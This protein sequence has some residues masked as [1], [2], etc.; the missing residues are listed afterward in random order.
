[1]RL[2]IDNHKVKTVLISRG[3]S[4]TRFVDKSSPVDVCNWC[5]TRHDF[6]DDVAHPPY[7]D[8]EYHCA[9]CGVEL[10]E[11]DDR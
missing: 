10:T 11:E 5:Y 1:M 6:D 3:V 7:S 9:I 4:I 8:D 2:D